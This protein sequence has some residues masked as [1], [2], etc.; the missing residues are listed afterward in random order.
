MM[1][2][3]HG[4]LTTLQGGIEVLHGITGASAAAMNH[5]TKKETETHGMKRIR[6]AADIHVRLPQLRV[7]FLRSGER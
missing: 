1:R 5:R 4:R 6:L 2:T 3:A 7:L